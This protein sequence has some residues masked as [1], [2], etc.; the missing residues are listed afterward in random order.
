[1]DRLTRFELRKIIKRK[2]FLLAA[3]ILLVLLIFVTMINIFSERIPQETGKTVTGLQA[4]RLKKQYDLQHTGALDANKIA[5]AIDRYH[6]VRG[7]R[8]TWILN[9][10]RSQT[11]HMLNMK[12]RITLSLA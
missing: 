3:L 11:G 7:I 8:I 12:L 10:K 1:M 9:Q 4:I 6:E 5:G 2:S